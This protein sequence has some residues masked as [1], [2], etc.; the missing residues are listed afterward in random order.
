MI[1]VMSENIPSP[2]EPVPDEYD[3]ICEGCGYSLI[4][5]MEVSR[6]PECGREFDP[7]ELPLARV[8]WLYRARL[9]NGRA[10]RVTVLKILKDPAGFAAEL[11]RPSRISL[12]DARQFRRR[13]I[14]HGVF[15][16][17]LAMLAVLIAEIWIFFVN[18][19][20]SILFALDN[21]IPG[22]LV[23]CVITICVWIFL[24]LATDLP[25]FIWK[26][27]GEDPDDLAP[28]HHYASAP[29]AFLPILA[30]VVGIVVVVSDTEFA[31]RYL[32]LLVMCALG[33]IMACLLW[34]TAIIFMRVAGTAS[35]RQLWT[36]RIYLLIHWLIMGSLSLLLSLLALYWSH[37]LLQSM[38]FRVNW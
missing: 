20:A 5:L 4:G 7:T 26:G 25:T 21:S 22:F 36:L 30:V 10:Y 17:F 35:R 24:T 8:P 31:R 19:R 34:R 14:R 9:G 28:I 1:F 12:Q 37:E 2:A 6:C 18:A 38:G 15:A 13:T 11:C 32:P 23:I 29:L 33:L 3:Q 16:C 27:L